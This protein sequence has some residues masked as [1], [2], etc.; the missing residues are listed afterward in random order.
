M[1]R[2]LALATP[3]VLSTIGFGDV[4]GYVDFDGREKG[5]IGYTNRAYSFVGAGH[6]TYAGQTSP[7]T[8][9][10]SNWPAD[11]HL[12][13][14]D[15]QQLGPNGEPLHP[16][17]SDDSVVP[18][19]GNTLNVDDTKGFCG[20]GSDENALFVINRTN[21]VANGPHRVD[22][23]FD[24]ENYENL[25]FSVDLVA[26]SLY[27][28]DDN[29][30]WEYSIDGAPFQSLIT[31]GRQGNASQTYT[32]DDG[33]EFDLIN[34]MRANGIRITDEY[35]NVAAAI[36]G[37]GSRLRLRF[38]A[39]STGYDPF[40]FDN[41]QVDG[42]LALDVIGLVDFSG[43]ELGLIEY[44]NDA[45][46]YAGSG[47]G[48]DANQLE[49][50]GDSGWDSRSA[51]WPLSRVD[52]GPRF[53][54]DATAVMPG[55]LSDDSVAPSAGR[56][57]DAQDAHGLTS[58][59]QGD[60]GFFGI[61]DTRSSSASPVS[62]EFVFD[63]S[64]YQDLALSIDLM[65]MGNFEFAD[66]TTFRLEYSVDGGAYATAFQVAPAKGREWKM[67][68]GEYKTTSYSL[69]VGPDVLSDIPQR[70]TTLI[71]EIGSELTL[72]VSA[73]IGRAHPNG[74]A[75]DNIVLRGNVD[76]PFTL[77]VASSCP[78]A[79]PATM[80]TINGSG[81]DVAFVYSMNGSGGFIIP[82]GNPCAG[83]S[84]DLAGPVVLG[85]IASGDPAILDIPNVPG[86]ACGGVTLQA[87]DL[88]T[89]ETSNVVVFE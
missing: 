57:L 84:L 8:G 28:S 26:M 36:A 21:A 56:T 41:V 78:D 58:I 49:E 46:S 15:R 18:A 1:N 20:M 32:M 5:L 81:G 23:V 16:S 61:R 73:D 50:S 9:S 35:T 4:I 40:G 68:S 69:R 13:P 89:C 29:F 6:G 70:F 54:N 12:W 48:T 45:Y 87:L 60:D 85:G 63:I 76:P 10:W 27:E 74:F 2:I 17:V 79:G 59:T 51:F 82:D 44:T 22:F 38:A 37:T 11:S 75:M 33:D 39:E 25:M 88:S 31:I 65:A 19:A 71:P 66:E 67:D 52:R 53:V 80:Q 34:P 43:T 47:L 30:S 86:N 55:A 7:T 83:I 42:D 62:S 3:L 64:G 14:F 72:R 24:I 77:S